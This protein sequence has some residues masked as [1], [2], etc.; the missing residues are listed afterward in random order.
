MSWGQR[1]ARASETPGFCIWM[2]PG[3]VTLSPQ[4]ERMAV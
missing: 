4:V 3:L 2:I 1:R